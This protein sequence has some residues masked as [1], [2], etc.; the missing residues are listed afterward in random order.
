MEQIAFIGSMHKIFKIAFMQI[1]ETGEM[2][3]LYQQER[4]V[5]RLG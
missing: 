1:D 5:G 3:H 4:L 2:F